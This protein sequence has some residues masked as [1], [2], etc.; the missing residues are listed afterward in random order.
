[1]SAFCCPQRN[2]PCREKIPLKFL[3]IYIKLRCCQLEP[4][5][6]KVLDR[7]QQ[8]APP[9]REQN[10]YHISRF[11]LDRPSKFLSHSMEGAST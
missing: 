4:P 1:M 11:N 6:W 3:A 10:S 8:E 7:G 5:G 2:I 9:F